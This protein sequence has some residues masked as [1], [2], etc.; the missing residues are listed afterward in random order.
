MEY[1]RGVLHEGLTPKVYLKNV[2][3]ALVKYA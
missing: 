3:A 2:G 1:A